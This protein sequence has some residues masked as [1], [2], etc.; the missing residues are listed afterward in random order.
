[1]YRAEGATV[2]YVHDVNETEELFLTVHPTEDCIKT[3]EEQAVVLA[4]VLNERDAA[5]V[6]RWRAESVP[7]HEGDDPSPTAEQLERLQRD[8]DLPHPPTPFTY[9][10]RLAMSGAGP[11]AYNW[12][13]KPHRLVYDL[14]RAIEQ[15]AG[16]WRHGFRAGLE[17]A[18]RYHDETVK[19]FQAVA[20]AAQEA[21]D[22]VLVRQ[23]ADA[24]RSGAHGAQMDADSAQAVAEAIDRVVGRQP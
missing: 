1:M 23:F 20:A 14:C 5:W 24:Y 15:Q 11:H 10:Y 17:R 19:E 18:A 2:V 22:L 13:D 3:P 21:E 4:N 16:E 6:A 7:G 9:W 12:S 8:A